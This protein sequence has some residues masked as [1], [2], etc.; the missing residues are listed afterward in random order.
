MQQFMW[1]NRPAFGRKVQVE[2]RKLLY[3]AIGYITSDWEVQVETNKW[4]WWFN[5]DR[6]NICLSATHAV[7]KTTK[8]H[9]ISPVLKS[10]HWLKINDSIKCN[11]LSLS[12]IFKSLKTGQLSYLR[13]LLSFPSHR[14]TRYSSLI[15]LSHPS[16]T[17]CI[18]I[19]N[20]ILS[21]CSCFVEQSPIWSTLRCSSR[22]SFIYI[23]LACMWFFNIFFSKNVKSHLFHCFS[24]LDCVHLSYP[25][26]DF[27][28]I[29]QAYCFISC[30]HSLSFHLC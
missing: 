13:S 19:A 6:C 18:K 16:L 23:K 4:K 15:T 3:S 25:M 17:S 21:F 12:L 20:I 8:F 26:I 5:S 10:L 30:Y 29:D 27:S 1:A 28:D 24:S 22:H 7:T 2:K 9:H 11:A 14:S